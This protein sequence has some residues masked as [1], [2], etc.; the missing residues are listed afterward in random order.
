MP[1]AGKAVHRIPDEVRQI[2]DK[3]ERGGRK[4]IGQIPALVAKGDHQEQRREQ[5]IGHREF[6]EQA[7]PGGDADDDPPAPRRVVL[8]ASP[9]EGVE[10]DGPAQHERHVGRHDRGGQ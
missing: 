9:D 7:D 8:L 4:E 10:R 1:V 5:P 2:D 3:G 6:G